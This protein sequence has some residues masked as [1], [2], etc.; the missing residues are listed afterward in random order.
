MTSRRVGLWS[1]LVLA[2]VLSQDL[3]GGQVRAADDPRSLAVKAHGLLEQYCHRCHGKDGS[4][5]GGMNY[6]LDR[7]KLIA[8]KK[9]VPGDALHSPLY[10][11][12]ATGK[13][14]P[15]DEKPRPSAADVALLKR[16]IEGG[17]SAPCRRSLNGGC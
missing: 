10:K 14:P 5:E 8:R 6:V 4:L 11:R 12:L 17:A 16:W 2:G 3:G 1:L 7:D 9:I 13:M 15:P